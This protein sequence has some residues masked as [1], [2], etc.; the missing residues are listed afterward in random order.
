M[1]IIVTGSAGRLGSVTVD[2]LRKKGHIVFGVDAGGVEHFVLG[3][4]NT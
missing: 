1:K 2:T 3:C 4:T